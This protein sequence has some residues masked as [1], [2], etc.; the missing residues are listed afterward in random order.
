MLAVC[1]ASSRTL[2]VLDLEGT[3]LT[4]QPRNGATCKRE[5]NQTRCKKQDMAWWEAWA[6]KSGARNRTWHGGRHGQPNQVQ[7]TVHGMV[8]G[9]G[10]QTR[11]KKQDMAWWEAWDVHIE[12]GVD[13]VRCVH[14]EEEVDYVRCVHIEEEEDCAH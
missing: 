1:V 4:N 12:E 13:C 3:G 11:C 9:L 10:N 7:E 6:T 14:I 2:E 8:G 5:S